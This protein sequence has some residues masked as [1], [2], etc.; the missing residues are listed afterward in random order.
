ME[1]CGT[2]KIGILG[3]IGPE[4]TGIFYSKLIQKF[5]RDESIQSNKDFP[6]I[7]INSIPA[8]ELVFGEISEDELKPYIEG[9]K[10]LDDFKPYF[11]VMVCNTIHL[12]YDRLQKEIQTPILDLRE[13]M[14]N[15]LSREGI[16]SVLVLGTP[17]TM[18]SGL[19]NFEEIKT[20]LLTE[21][22]IDKISKTIF[23]FNKGADVGGRI[24]NL[25]DIC[26]EYLDEVDSVI[27]GCTELGIMLNNVDFPSINTIDV[28]VEETIDNLEE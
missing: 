5:Q 13:V 22:Q 7:F 10:E 18:K 11:I 2:N 19:Y 24:E 15:Y 4:A 26:R 12:F 28:L 3:G 8:P 1:T 14:R 21:E 16:E 6:H 17:S 25:K 9:L 27:L 23:K 20:V